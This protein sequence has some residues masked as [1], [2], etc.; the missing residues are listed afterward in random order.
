MLKVVS[1]VLLEKIKGL[2]LISIYLIPPPC[3]PAGGVKKILQYYNI[4]V[5]AGIVS[6]HSADNIYEYRI[7]GVQNCQNIFPYFDNH[8]LKSN[9][10]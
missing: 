7:G 8:T 9:F 5:F 3:S 4:C 10:L 2:V 6:K 1:L